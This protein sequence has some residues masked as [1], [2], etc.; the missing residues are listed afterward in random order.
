MATLQCR[1]VVE[2]EPGRWAEATSIA[3]AQVEFARTLPGTIGYDIYADPEGNTLVQLA[4]Y[5]D[6]ASW[7]AHSRSNPFAADYMKV[8][9]VKAL[10]V[11]GES[12]P[13]LDEILAAYGAAQQFTTVRPGDE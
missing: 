4:T 6:V 12:T 9:R 2:V 3:A 8:V 5:A 11:Y 7:L 1:S 13:E 10:E